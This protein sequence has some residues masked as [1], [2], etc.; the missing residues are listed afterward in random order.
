MQK[1]RQTNKHCH[2]EGKAQA[3][4]R[5]VIEIRPDYNGRVYFCFFCGHYHVGREKKNAKKNKYKK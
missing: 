5:S 3:H 4:L 1:C 2:T